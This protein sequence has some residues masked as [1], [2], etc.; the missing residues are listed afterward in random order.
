MTSLLVV[1]VVKEVFSLLQVVLMVEVEEVFSLLEVVLVKV[2]EV[3]SLL[4]VVL[5]MEVFQ[6]CLVLLCNLPI[7]LP[8]NQIPNHHRI[9]HQPPPHRNYH[10]LTQFHHNVVLLE[11]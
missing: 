8:P 3:F 1:V 10:H 9:F 5:E 2:E 7:P 4:G 11:L 6:S